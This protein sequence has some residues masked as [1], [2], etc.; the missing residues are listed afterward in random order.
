[1]AYTHPH[2]YIYIYIWLSTPNKWRLWVRSQYPH[3]IP[4][5]RTTMVVEAM[6]RNFKRLVL[7]LYNRPRVG[8]DLLAREEWRGTY[9]KKLQIPGSLSLLC[10]KKRE[11]E[12]RLG[13]VG[14]R[15]GPTMYPL[16]ISG[17]LFFSHV[18][19]GFLKHTII[20]EDRRC[21]HFI[22]TKPCYY[23]LPPS[24][25]MCAPLAYFISRLPYRRSQLTA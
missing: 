9:R 7:H 22:C 23:C 18:P 21:F 25:F 6:W 13:G 20:I 12:E 14:P 4:R 16:L 5:K 17:L 8:R 1:M 24:D 19:F 11:R 2:I 3:Y 15:S 10:W